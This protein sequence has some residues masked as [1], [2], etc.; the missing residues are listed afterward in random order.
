[1]SGQAKKPLGMM[2]VP[3]HLTAFNEARIKPIVLAIIRNGEQIAVESL[4]KL[5]TDFGGNLEIFRSTSTFDLIIAMPYKGSGD[6]KLKKALEVLTGS[7]VIDTM[8]GPGDLDR[9]C[10]KEAG[11]SLFAH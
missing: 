11:L 10:K 7:P 8:T 2:Y 5:Q 4:E 1:M 3:K 9:V 6:K